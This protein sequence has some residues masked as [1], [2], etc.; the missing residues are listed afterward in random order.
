MR[1]R[2]RIPSAYDSDDRIQQLGTAV[3]ANPQLN[4]VSNVTKDAAGNLKSQ[5]FGNGVTENHSYATDG[6]AVNFIVTAPTGGAPGGDIDGDVPT[7]PEWGMI[8][9]GTLLLGMGLRRQ[10]VRGS[11]G[12]RWPGGMASLFAVLLLL[13]LFAS[14]PAL[15]DEALTYDANGNRL[16]DGSGYY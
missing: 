15:A 3:G 13:P 11:R 12:P 16:S 7:L 9:L 4:L 8:L 6:L 5:S 10:P 14:H 1:D 2:P